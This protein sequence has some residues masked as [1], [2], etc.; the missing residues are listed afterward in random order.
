MN[1]NDD[2]TITVLASQFGSV[3][4]LVVN[5]QDLRCY[6]F[7]LHNTYRSIFTIIIRQQEALGVLTKLAI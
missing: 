5:K 7:M 6:P 2:K 4:S 3:Y 1:R